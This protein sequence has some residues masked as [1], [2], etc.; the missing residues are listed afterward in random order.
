MSEV[1]GQSVAEVNH[2]V[3]G[4]VLGQPACLVQ[5]GFEFEV[6][7]FGRAAE[8][9][10]DEDGVA[11]PGAGS[12]DGAAAGDPAP[13]GYGEEEAARVARGFTAH[14]GDVVAS[15]QPGQAGIDA[16]DA[17]RVGSLRQAECNQCGEGLTAHGGHVAEA[18]GQGLVT[19]FFGWCVRGEMDALDHGI[20]F[21][22]PVVVP[23]P[24]TKHG[25]VVSWGDDDLG[26]LR[27]VWEE[28][29]DECELV[30]GRFQGPAQVC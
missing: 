10:G 30:H 27:Q 22:Q 20:G 19:D 13:E 29:F 15:S 4:E 2:G 8:F 17:V 5:A 12:E 6:F 26:A 14:H 23:V 24:G 7:A 9:A 11:G 16:V 18:A 21:E 28:A 3:D 1:A 25:A